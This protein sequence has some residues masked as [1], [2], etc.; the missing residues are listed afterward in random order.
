[1]SVV[2]LYANPVRVKFLNVLTLE[3]SEVHGLIRTLTLRN[4]YLVKAQLSV[5]EIKS[6]K[7]FRVLSLGAK[8][9]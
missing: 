2:A 4:E 3:L 6:Q 5:S 9:F 8:K 1:M 7:R